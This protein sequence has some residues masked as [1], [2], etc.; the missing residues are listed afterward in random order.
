[1]KYEETIIQLNEAQEADSDL[2]ES[3]REA[4]LFLAKRDGQW[5]PYWWNQTE[6]RPRYTF[7]MTTP[8]VKQNANAL[9]RMQY[10]VSVLPGNGETS[11]QDATFFNGIIRSIQNNSAAR[12]VYSHAARG[13]VI[14]GLDGWIVR[15]DYVTSNSFDQ[16]LSIH[17]VHNFLDSVW[18]DPG[19]QEMTRSDADF[20]WVLQM[21]PKREYEKR[22]PKGSGKSLD[23]NLKYNA[24]YNK[25]DVVII[26]QCYYKKRVPVSLIQLSD[27]RVLEETDEIK[28]VLPFLQ[29]NGVQVTNSR[30]RERTEIHTY[31]F[32]GGDQLGESEKTIF[33]N[34][35][36]VVPVVANHEIIEN[37][38]IY[39]GVV[40][41]L[42]DPQRVY[43]YAKSR[44]T[45]E[46]A[47]APRSKYWMTQAQAEGHEEELGT[48]N[49]NADPV[50][51]Y[52][53]DPEAPGV[54]QQQGGAQINPG[55]TQLSG[56]MRGL[57][58][59]VAGMFAA[60]MGDNPGLQ[61][62]IAIERLQDRGDTGNYDYVEALEMSI[63][64]TGKIL[65][66]AIP[67]AYAN[68]QSIQIMDVDGQTRHV[69]VNQMVQDRMTGQ[70]TVIN[71]LAKGKY[72]VVCKAGPSFTSQQA[73][74]VKSMTEVAQYDP[75]VM[76][77][78]GDIFFQNL[79][80][81]G[82]SLVAERKRRKLF[83]GGFIPPEQ[84]TE[85]EQQE[86]MQKMQ[87]PPPPD[88][89]MVLAQAEADKA[90]AQTQKV[91]AEAQGTAVKLQLEQ[92]K[93]QRAA[94]RQE[95]EL[96]LS[97][98]QQEFAQMR[99]MMGLMLEERK[100]VNES[101]KTQAETLKLIREAI[102]ADSIVDP[103]AVKSYSTQSTIVQDGQNA[104][105]GGSS[106]DIPITGK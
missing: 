6:S 11:K 97:A 13:M 25:T 17:K 20:C 48:L 89:N 19:A 71:D 40:E 69:P 52:N 49:T 3:A 106:L 80:T 29:Q 99:D 34:Y 41:K 77:I 57:M 2:R 94:S 31:L 65:V 55:L 37:K 16:D 102:G 44:E 98:A 24:W 56:D 46:G 85:Q 23:Q 72:S 59:Q 38:P 75:S 1:M 86:F 68:R 42:M 79:P 18:F 27:G 45:E 30:E 63:E 15:H 90:E 88:P 39:F 70:V 22:F 84:M 67:R 58:G 33:E 64:H 36:P 7:D 4:K 35:L 83:E 43:N 12:H 60:N 78:G 104:V 62:G 28:R 51:F 10:D 61:T 93:N 47:L 76:E 100:Q 101:L 105:Q 54:P 73:E 8:I 103:K 32:D 92:E 26:G 9:S 87:Q 91:L 21:L 95:Q 74:T 14:S 66:D 50:Q 81:P 53:S 82:M 96:M 5:E